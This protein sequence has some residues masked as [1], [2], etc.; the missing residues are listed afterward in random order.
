MPQLRWS[1]YSQ[2]VNLWL[3]P[4]ADARDTWLPLMR[5]VACEGRCFVLSA[6]QCVKRKHLPEWIKEHVGQ[7]DGES[8]EDFVCTG[9]SCIVNPLGEVLKGPLW[10]VEEEEDSENLSNLLVVEANFEEC[11]KGRLDIDIGGSYSRN[12]AF[13]LTV[14]GLDTSPPP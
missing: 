6:N 7:K 13:K 10:K 9:G 3:A 12:D 11:L 14:E 8:E 4:T 2:D 5:T 1:L